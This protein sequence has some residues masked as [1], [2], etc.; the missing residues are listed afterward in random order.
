MTRKPGDAVRI[1]ENLVLRVIEV[2]GR[3][4]KIGIEAPKDVRIETL[5]PQDVPTPVKK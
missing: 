4:V 1:G 3:K 5:E 2:Q